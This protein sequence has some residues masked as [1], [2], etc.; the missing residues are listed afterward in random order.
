MAIYALGDRR[1]TIHE[2]AYV[3]PEAM[4]IGSVEL[5]AQASVWPGAVIRADDNKIVI[6]ARS[7]VQD[8]AVLHCTLEL[9]TLVGED[10]TIGHLA[11]L[12]GCTVR[13]RALVGVGSKVLHR[14]VVGE[15]SIVGANAVATNNLDIPS[16]SMALGVPAKIR[17]G[18][19]E[20]GANLAFAESYVHRADRYRNELILW[21]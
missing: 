18:V 9:A 13:D 15:D 6:G 1:P 2:T 16:C 20:K 19:L 21:T 14:A 17:E 3:H 5:G 4:I 10:V 11:H 8:N 12:E 7:N